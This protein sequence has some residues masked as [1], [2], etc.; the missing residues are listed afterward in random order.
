LHPITA[1]DVPQTA[2]QVLGHGNRIVDLLF[3]HGNFVLGRVIIDPGFGR[4][5][6]TKDPNCVNNDTICLC[7]NRQET[8]TDGLVTYFKPS[9]IAGF[10][11]T[12]DAM[13]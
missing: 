13:R 2:E 7:I 4:Q 6:C 1:T 12:T 5:V 3:G 9:P 11:L 8:F 10:G